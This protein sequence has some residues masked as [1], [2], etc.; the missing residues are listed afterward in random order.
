M[1]DQ[2]I[3]I[4]IKEVLDFCWCPK[5]YELKHRTQ[6]EYNL[7]EAYDN[8]LHKV[9]YAYLLA[10]QND[11]LT[12]GIDFLKYR[13][14][15]EWI[16]QKTNSEILITPSSSKRDTHNS[17]RKAGIDAI[18][19]FDK[20]IS[21]PQYPVIINKDYELKITDNII[22]TGIWEYVREIEVGGENIFQVMKFRVENN[23]F[24]MT[25]LM[26]H[27]LELTA[28]SLAF[29]KTFNVSEPPQLVYMDIYKKK[30]VT[31]YRTQKDYDLL[32]QTVISVVKCIKHDIK[33]ISPDKRCYH[34][35]Y[36]DMCVKEL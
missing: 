27:D 2:E 21:T 34:C 28:A 19:T 10:L 11:T 33:C 3:R 36:R 35:E 32:K 25:N 6:N 16:K 8:T 17:K 14:G 7:K 30:L 26:D 20:L 12:K 15:K 24:Q 1:A 9:F 4:S 29:M 23:R 5:Y 18:I 22:L 31:S 13:W